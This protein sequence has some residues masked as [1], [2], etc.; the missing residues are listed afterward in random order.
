M[1][2]WPV[3]RWWRYLERYAAGFAGARARGCR[4]HVDRAGTLAAGFV[5]RDV[6]RAD[7]GR[8]WS[9]WAPGP[10]SVRA[11]RRERATLPADLLQIDVGEYRNPEALP[12]GRVLVVGSGQSGCQ[13]A[14]ELH[15]AGREVFLACGRAPWVPRRI[16]DHDVIW[17]AVETGFYDAPVSSLPHP[18]AAARRQ[19]AVDGHAAAGTTCTTARCSRWAS[20]CSGTS[21]GPTAAAPASRPIS[22]RASRGAISSTRMLMNAVRATAAAR[23]M[24]APPIAEPLPFS[25]DAPEELDLS[26]FGAVIFA[27]GFRPDYV[28]GAVAGRVRRVRVPASARRS[29][30]ACTGSVL[31]RGAFPAQAQV[32]AADRGRRGRRDRR[33]SDR[34]GDG[35][36]SRVDHDAEHV[37]GPLAAR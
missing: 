2:S 22:A 30:H 13:I 17:W 31:H 34:R 7:R 16:G 1:L 27:S 24:P 26:G 5:L 37:R 12:A 18:G 3:M 33:A 11:A 15:E 10:T 25:A 8:D 36:G 23:D 9:S 20:P 29:Q 28:V 6:R 21:S 4:S 19:R 35:A 32:G 14:E